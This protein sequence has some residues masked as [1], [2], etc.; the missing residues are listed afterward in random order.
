MIKKLLGISGEAKAEKYIKKLGY[1]ILERNYRTKQGEIDIIASKDNLIVFIEVKTRSNANY[2]K[3]Y[4]SVNKNKCEKIIRTA[5]QYMLNHTDKLAR[6]DVI[7]I[8][9][10]EISHIENAFTL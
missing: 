3:G 9:D 6:F 4:E 10:G 8:D 5:E 1:K 7:S 2:G